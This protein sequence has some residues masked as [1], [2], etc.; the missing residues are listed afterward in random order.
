MK[1]PEK[2]FCDFC[3]KEI[4]KSTTETWLPVIERIPT[5]NYCFTEVVGFHK[6]DICSDCLRKSTNIR[7][8]FDGESPRIE[9]A[10][11]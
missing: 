6:Y 11:K 7:C 2:Y 8:E 1:Q 10:T 4:C 9:E 3:G 5:D